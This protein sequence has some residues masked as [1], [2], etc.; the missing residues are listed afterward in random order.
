[1]VTANQERFFFDHYG[2][3]NHDLE[4]FLYGEAIRLDDY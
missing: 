3:T 4:I 1:M 2:L